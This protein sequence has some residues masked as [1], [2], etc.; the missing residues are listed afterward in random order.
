MTLKR[1]Y[2]NIITIQH[3]L[4]SI[5]VVLGLFIIILNITEIKF[6]T[7]TKKRKLQNSQ[8]YLLNLSASDLMTGVG[9]TTISIISMY[10]SKNED[11][12]IQWLSKIQIVFTLAI[13]RIT[14]FMSIFALI[15]L[16]IDRMLGVLRPLRH[17]NTHSK[18]V[19]G[20]CVTMWVLSIG[21]SVLNIT[22]NQ[23]HEAQ[24]SGNVHQVMFQQNFTGISLTH[25]NLSIFAYYI[26]YSTTEETIPV[27]DFETR[28]PKVNIHQ[29]EAGDKNM[30]F[31]FDH[32]FIIYEDGN[33]YENIDP[34]RSEMHTSI[35][36]TILPIL[37][38]S[39]I[40]FLLAA[41][42]MIWYRLRKSKRR[43]NTETEAKKTATVRKRKE[44][45][46]IMLSIGIVVA[47]A[48]CWL[49]LTIF[50]TLFVFGVIS[51]E[52]QTRKEMVLSIP[53]V[54]NSLLNPFLYFKIM[55]KLD[56]GLMRCRKRKDVR[57]EEGGNRQYVQELTK[58]T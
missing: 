1:I 17:R 32:D 7:K 38:Y 24:W 23:K 28:Y 46:F 37:V 54:L 51:W 9:I 36:Y 10:Q 16:T 21:F 33:F 26:E 29:Y 12:V 3:P 11:K 14:L 39:T 19:I 41:Y 56:C 42:L 13:F 2:V 30:T 57:D 6:I 40:I 47:F 5:F 22:L 55:N 53:L 20:L 35:E 43:L 44:R 58:I 49:P 8:Y 34:F 31:F 52:E 4:D 25:Y 50:E 15:V 27:I 45:R 48:L 18:H